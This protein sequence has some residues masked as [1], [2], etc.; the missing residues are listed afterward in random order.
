M[1]AVILDASVVAKCLVPEEG[2][3]EARRLVAEAHPLFAP[4]LVF[5]EAANVVWKHARGD[6]LAA[7]RIDGLLTDL[8]AIPLRALPMRSLTPLALHLAVKHRHSVYDCYYL[9][10]AIQRSCPLATAD[11]RLAAL[12]REVG[13]SDRVILIGEGTSR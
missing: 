2:T 12:A 11:R 5:A 6:A 9:A 13:L 4:A 3:T 1:S 10:A 7:E 8:M